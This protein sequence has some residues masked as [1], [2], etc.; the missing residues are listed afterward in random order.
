MPAKK[1]AK[2]GF[3]KPAKTSSKKPA[4]LSAK[5]P[6]KT[7]EKTS[8]KKPAL[9]SP[10]K[11]K[12]ADEAMAPTQHKVAKSK[13]STLVPF[14]V[15]VNLEVKPDRLAEFLPIIQGDA[16]GSVQNEVGCLRFDVLQDPGQS[17]KFIFYEVYKDASCFATHQTMPH[18]QPWS[19][20]FGDFST[21]KKHTGVLTFSASLN[22]GI[23]MTK[24]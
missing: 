5:K 14:V 8:V 18:F 12:E 13:S 7:N 9:K 6:I 17:N 22:Q 15:V 4:K 24:F 23:Y 19:K 1:P 11:R 21:T 2:K 10:L 20:F 3:K 16:A